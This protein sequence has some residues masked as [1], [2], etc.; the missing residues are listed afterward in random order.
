MRRLV[1]WQKGALLNL[2]MWQHSYGHCTNT[3]VCLLNLSD[4]CQ[5]TMLYFLLKTK[6]KQMMKDSITNLY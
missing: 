2:M 5:T 3:N 4:F 1:K 6:I